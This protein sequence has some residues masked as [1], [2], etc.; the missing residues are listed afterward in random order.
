MNKILKIALFIIMFLWL[1]PFF[2][3]IALSIGHYANLLENRLFLFSLRNSIFIGLLTALLVVSLASWT[4]FRMTRH[5]LK[6][7]KVILLLALIVS[8][9]PQ[10]SVAGPLFIVFSRISLINTLSGL[11]LVYT[12]FSLPLVLWYLYAYFQKIP[13]TLDEA[14]AVD[15]AGPW[16]IFIKIILPQ[17]IPALTVSGVLVF[18]FV[19]NEFFLGFVL[20]I[21][22]HARP[23]PTALAL[24]TSRYETNWGELSAAS[25]IAAIPVFLLSLYT[26]KAFMME[27]DELEE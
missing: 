6:L 26:K 24:F 5:N 21:D 1:M 17:S 3:T 12:T 25:V 11:I 27:K 9:Y 23:L 22:E 10:V 8:I 7:T 16:T 13:M 18:L 20:T 2:W 14:A 15:G 4:A 19:W